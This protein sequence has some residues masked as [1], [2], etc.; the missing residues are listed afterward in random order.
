MVPKATL[1]TLPQYD[2]AV[3]KDTKL[4]TLAARPQES[5]VRT[6]GQ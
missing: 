4:P 2:E 6:L 5:V 3:M 1:T